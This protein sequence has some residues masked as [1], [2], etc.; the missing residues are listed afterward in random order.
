MDIQFNYK[1]EQV[2]QMLEEVDFLDRKDG[3]KR[4]DA[5]VTEWYFEN[6]LTGNLANLNSQ[7]ST[8][9]LYKDD[10]NNGIRHWVKII[11]RSSYSDEERKA[12]GAIL[13]AL[14]RT[15]QK[16]QCRGH[17]FH[18]FSYEKNRIK[19]V[20]LKKD[21]GSWKQVPPDQ[22]LVKILTTAKLKDALE[23]LSKPI[24]KSGSEH[25]GFAQIWL[26][27]MDEKYLRSLLLQRLFM[28]F[29]LPYSLDVDAI[30]LL[31]DKLTFHEF[32]RK[33]PCPQGHF[34]LNTV[35]SFDLSDIEKQSRKFKLKCSPQE[36][37]DFLKKSFQVERDTNTSVF[38]LDL[39][40]FKMLEFCHHLGIAYRYCIW[41]SSHCMA[42]YKDPATLDDL[43]D[44]VTMK[45]KNGCYLI[46]NNLVP[47]YAKGFVFTG[48]GKSGSFSPNTL[49]IQATFEQSK[50]CRINEV[51]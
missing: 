24:S 25:K 33:T 11:D 44:P 34:P 2:L 37:F 21:N 4:R 51:S 31:E 9:W 18:K 30:E 43:F 41:N 22:A 5:Y 42:Q 3:S 15:F 50:F 14:H 13:N 27:G 26:K 45:T 16:D 36:L 23:K 35:N 46:S 7:I 38:G 28:N 39:S 32:K 8:G 47:T 20:T 49:R 48:W 6:L 17:R 1:P 40:H 10:R 12:D 29:T 19:V